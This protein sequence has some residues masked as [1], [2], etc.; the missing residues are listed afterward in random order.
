MA[1][2]RRNSAL[3]YYVNG[4]VAKDLHGL[5]D[6]AGKVLSAYDT[7]VSRAVVGLKRRALPAASRAVREHYGIAARE[8]TGKFRLESG[9]KGRRGD[10]SDYISI[11]ASTRRISLLAFSGRWSGRRSKGATASIMKG[12]KKLY[13]GSFIATVRGLRA[14]RMRSRDAS[15]KRN[16]RGPLVMLRG[17]SP[18]E[19][20]SG[21]DYEP[22]R[23]SRDAVLS[24][25]TTFY[26]A[27]LRRQFKLN[28]VGR[29]Q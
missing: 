23:A 5:T 14:I 2:S 12:T 28:G 19:M 18:F 3:K 17:P 22:S 29:G 26:R 24:E 1:A 9:S 20:L 15:G 6:I 10:R 4:R 21:V 27:E 25:L 7:A 11:W 13:G 8:L 16:P